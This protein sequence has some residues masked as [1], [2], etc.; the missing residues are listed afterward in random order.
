[1]SNRAEAIGLSFSDVAGEKAD[2]ASKTKKKGGNQKKKPPYFG[3][4]RFFKQLITLVV[5][6]VISGLAG[7]VAWL[8][9][10]QDGNEP[11]TDLHN[12]YVPEAGDGR[13]MLSVLSPENVDEWRDRPPAQDT[14]FTTQMTTRWTFDTWDTP[15]KNG[16]IGNSENNSR[17]IYMEV[18]L[19]EEEDEFGEM[20]YSS[21]Y[22]PVGAVLNNFALDTYVPAGEHETVVVYYL[23]D[24][25]FNIITDTRVAVWITV[26]A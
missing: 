17:I 10:F 24:D 26:L 18:Y 1:M 14:H 2:R 3:S 11:R 13:G 6:L 15:T 16:I 23:V 8:I 25:D 7:V 5:V 22:I 21:P 12:L 4:T 20:I 19:L 9:W